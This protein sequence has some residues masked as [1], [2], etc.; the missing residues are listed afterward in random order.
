MRA[1]L[2]TPDPRAVGAGGG[3]AVFDG[4][5]RLDKLL[6]GMA[7]GFAIARGSLIAAEHVVHRT[8]D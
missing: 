3:A 5:V 7:F 8:T 4:E 1:K 6:P 2:N